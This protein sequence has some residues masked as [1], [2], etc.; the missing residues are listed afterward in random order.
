MAANSN[1]RVKPTLPRSN[2]T[3]LERASS[4]NVHVFV[5]PSPKKLGR[6]HYVSPAYLATATE[7][8]KAALHDLFVKLS[9]GHLPVRPTITHF[10]DHTEEFSERIY[11]VDPVKALFAD[12]GKVGL[13]FTGELD[14]LPLLEFTK[15]G[16]RFPVL[17]IAGQTAWIVSFKDDLFLDTGR[18]SIR[19]VYVSNTKRA[20]PFEMIDEFEHALAV[21]AKQM[22]TTP[23]VVA[24][25]LLTDEQTLGD[26]AAAPELGVAPLTDKNGDRGPPQ[27]ITAET[28]FDD[29]PPALQTKPRQKYNFPAELLNDPKAIQRAQSIVNA[30]KYKTRKGIE[31]TTD[32]ITR[33]QVAASL[34]RQSERRKKLFAKLAG[35]LAEKLTR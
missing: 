6:A 11:N 3:L 20:K 2:I 16:Y 1:L 13:L 26:A 30:R 22:N 32:E 29:V 34:V 19:T 17:T 23:E 33:A 15:Y 25:R 10:V 31:L 28:L 9:R 8:E 5:P 4:D 18:H 7:R 35:K 24:R 14:I 12:Q 21:I 27:A